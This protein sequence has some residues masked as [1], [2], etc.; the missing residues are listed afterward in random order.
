MSKLPFMRLPV[1]EFV[2]RHGHLKTVER[3]ALFDIMTKQW[4]D[5]FKAID[6]D[7][8]QLIKYVTKLDRRQIKPVIEK[9]KPFFRHV[10]NKGYYNIWAE[11]MWDDAFILHQSSVDKGKKGA[12]ARQ[13][14]ALER[15]EKGNEE[16]NSLHADDKPVHS[17]DKKSLG[18]KENS[19]VELKQQ[20]KRKKNKTNQN[21]LNTQVINQ[22]FQPPL[23]GVEKP[24]EFSYQQFLIEAEELLTPEDL[25]SF[26]CFIFSKQEPSNWIGLIEKELSDGKTTEWILDW[27]KGQGFER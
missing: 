27:F 22:A 5:D 8:N 24:D 12:E 25:N 2:A 23:S 1:A 15:Q 7:D 18:N 14:I 26:E 6:L 16:T 19:L 21:I 3:G 10:H 4:M 17:E 20:S 9:I 13:K 11:P